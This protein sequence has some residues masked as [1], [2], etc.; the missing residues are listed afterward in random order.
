MVSFHRHHNS[1]RRPRN[2][3]GAVPTAPGDE[4]DALAMVPHDDP[5]VAPKHLHRLLGICLVDAGMVAQLTDDESST[6]IGLLS[7]LGEGDGARAAG[8]SA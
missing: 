6:F 3:R 5:Y 4:S 2:R 8:T 1:R 7:S